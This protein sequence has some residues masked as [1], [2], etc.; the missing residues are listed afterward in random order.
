M[1]IRTTEE[2]RFACRNSPDWFVSVV[3]GLTQA[4]IH[5]RIQSHL[6]DHDDCYIELHRGIG[7]T[8][9]ITT[10]LAWEI[11]RNP[12]IRIKLV[13]QNQPKASD[14]VRRVKRIIESKEFRWAFPEVRP[15]PEQ[16]GAEAMT[17]QRDTMDADP[18]LHAQG[19][20]GRAGGRYDLIVGDDICDMANAV[21]SPT[22]RERVKEFWANN[23]LPMADESRGETRCWQIGTP[24]HV[25]DIT[26]DWRAYYG[27]PR[28]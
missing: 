19:I 14:S 2:L 1:E 26:A 7:K 12:D 9:Q 28:S 13:Q 11:G 6:T 21:R 4:D 5:R 17:V 16:W 23:W 18:T 10:R 25:D 27:P 15:D 22:D 24:Y 3:G 20:F 8:V